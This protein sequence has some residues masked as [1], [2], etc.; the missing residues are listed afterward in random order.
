[1][2]WH[3]WYLHIYEKALRDE[4]G[5]TGYHP[6]RN[7]TPKW[8]R[9]P[10]GLLADDR[11]C[12]VLGLAKIRVCTGEVAHFQRR[13]VQLGRQRG[14]HPARRPHPCPSPGNQRGACAV[15]AG[16]R[17]RLRRHRAVCQHDDQ[18]RPRTT[19]AGHANGARPGTRL[20]SSSSEKRCGSGNNPAICQLHHHRQ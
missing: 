8:P 18:S 4:C 2:P 11:S 14:E 13:S 5:Y 3:R 19:S 9:M 1:M 12:T 20:Q 10:R 6:V 17:R 15:S 7:F 16:R